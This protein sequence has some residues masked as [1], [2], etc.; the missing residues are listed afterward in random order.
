[1]QQIEEYSQH[2]N[3]TL[4]HFNGNNNFLFVFV[5]LVYQ[6]NFYPIHGS[7]DESFWRKPVSLLVNCEWKLDFLVMWLAKQAVMYYITGWHKVV[8]YATTGSGV[9]VQGITDHQNV[10][11][12][13]VEL[14]GSPVPLLMLWIRLIPHTSSNTFQ[15]LYS[16]LQKNEPTLFPE[17]L[18]E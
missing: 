5:L 9:C 17:N 16:W 8:L 7:T 12:A 10:R 11:G 4:C 15:M 13:H 3:T 18:S 6:S 2:R 14:Y 1:M